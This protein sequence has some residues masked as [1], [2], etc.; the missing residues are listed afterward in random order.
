MLYLNDLKIHRVLLIWE[1]SLHQI[2]LYLLSF[3]FLESKVL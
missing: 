3:K 2:V 1:A